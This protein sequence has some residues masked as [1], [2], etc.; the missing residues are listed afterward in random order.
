MGT[1]AAARTQTR[2]ATQH[3]TRRTS[4]KLG[5]GMAVIL[6]A[7]GYLAYQGLQNSLVF[8]ITP[9]ELLQK[10]HAGLGVQLRI[11]GEVK[12][13][14]L[15]WAPNTHAISFVLQDYKTGVKVVSTTVPPAMLHNG[16]GAV[17]QGTWNGRVFNA[18]SIL[19]KH[20]ATYEPP[21]PG[22]KPPTDGQYVNK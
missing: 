20:D 16:G 9:T 12:P 17:V 8:Y 5:I 10:G 6:A 14:S 11:G 2:I 15:A 1:V 13:H 22:L 7:I 21:K 3:T 18:S 4:V 19:V